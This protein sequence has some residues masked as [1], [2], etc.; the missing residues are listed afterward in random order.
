MQKLGRVGTKFSEFRFG[1]LRTLTNSDQLTVSQ[2][3]DALDKLDAFDD[4]CQQNNFTVAARRTS[5]TSAGQALLN[6]RLLPKDSVTDEE[7]LDILREASE[8]N[9]L[10]LNALG[11]D[12]GT[13]STMIREYARWPVIGNVLRSV[14][15]RRVE[16][17]GIKK[18]KV[19][20]TAPVKPELVAEVMQAF[21]NEAASPFA[22]EL[23]A[24]MGEGVASSAGDEAEDC[25]MQ[26]EA[27]CADQHVVAT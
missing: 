9:A 27:A 26:L 6:K 8:V 12:Q 2:T 19:A 20:E 21:G 10:L 18:A 13:K 11:W 17:E 14:F 16:H 5:Y 1:V 24:A 23:E 4:I 22:D 3:V 25:E 15:K 7:H